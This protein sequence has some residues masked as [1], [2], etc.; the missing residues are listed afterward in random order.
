MMVSI[1]SGLR[2]EHIAILFCM[3][4][5]IVVLVRPG[6]GGSAE[7]IMHSVG[8]NGSKIADKLA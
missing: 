1:D 4:V 3:L 2:E 6:S 8:H 5:L 7:I